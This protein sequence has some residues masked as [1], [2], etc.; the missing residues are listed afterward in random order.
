[1]SES[2]DFEVVTRARHIVAM[3]HLGVYPDT[4]RELVAQITNFRIGNLTVK[5]QIA[6][7]C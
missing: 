4:P 3:F 5:R 7:S 2:D 6:K 1:M